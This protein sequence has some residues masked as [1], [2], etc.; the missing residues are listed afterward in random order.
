M[1]LVAPVAVIRT[2]PTLLLDLV[3]QTQF[4]FDSGRK[5]P[6]MPR[7]PDLEQRLRADLDWLAVPRHARWDE[8][9]L[10]T[11]RSRLLER[12]Q[13]LGPVEQ[14]RFQ[15][16]ADEV[17]N[18][19][20]RL[21]GQ[22]PELEPLLVAAHYDGPLGSPGAD[23][24]AS[25]V[26]ALLELARRWAVQPPQ[27]PLWLVAFDQEEWGM[28]GSRVLATELMQRNQPL[29]LM[30]SLEMLGYTSETQDYPHEEMRHL[31]GSRGDFIALVANN[32]AA[33]LLEDMEDQMI[34]HVPTRV[35]PVA[36]AGHDIPD[37]RLSDHSPFWDAGYNAMMVTDTSF[38]RNPHYHQPSDT[39]DTLDLPFLMAVINGLEAALSAL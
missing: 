11:V 5:K 10:L 16:G 14:H 19:I 27:R 34:R 3:L 2:S 39:V 22:R 25:G 24:N 26:V 28:I 18:L 17:V 15:E 30:V 23:D 13:D 35:L 8:L 20:L 1:A 21:P 32:D 29:H 6:E 38:M 12:L 4:R 31:F 37:V 9:G 36:D 33:P 7:P